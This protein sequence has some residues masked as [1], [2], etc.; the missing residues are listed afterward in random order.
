MAET[1]EQPFDIW[2]AIREIR[3]QN[4][5]LIDE[6]RAVLAPLLDEPWYYDCDL[7]ADPDT[8]VY[9]CKL[10]DATAHL[11]PGYGS[12]GEIDPPHLSSCPVL[13]R[14]ALLGR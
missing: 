11:P 7:D 8:M 9:V 13:R 1:T 2:A 10:C 12:I 14:D 4:E 5:A 3:E 6:L